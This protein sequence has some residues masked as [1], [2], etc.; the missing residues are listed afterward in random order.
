V[1]TD[2][3]NNVGAGFLLRDQAAVDS[4]RDREFEIR[5]VILREERSGR[6]LMKAMDAFRKV[7]GID[8]ACA[9]SAKIL[10]D[11]RQLRGK[12]ALV[13]HGAEFSESTTLSFCDLAAR[14]HLL[15]STLS[16]Q[17]WRS[18]ACAVLR[19]GCL[20]R[21]TGDAVGSEFFSDRLAHDVESRA[22]M[23]IFKQGVINE[24]L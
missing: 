9:P 13:S 23:N 10:F 7:V 11:F 15:C 3:F 6:A 20:V 18:A 14:F 24:G 16:V 2:N 4:V 8:L 19:L 22:A 12:I 5:V 1:A 21:S 17:Q